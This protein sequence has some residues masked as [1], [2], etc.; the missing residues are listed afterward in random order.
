[1]IAYADT[2]QSKPGVAHWWP[3]GKIKFRTVGILLL[4]C[5]FA[6]GFIL[7]LLNCLP[8]S[9]KSDFTLKMGNIH[10]L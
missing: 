5:I 8:T 4:L 6:H 9:K 2:Q 1:M 3:V 7:R 10:L